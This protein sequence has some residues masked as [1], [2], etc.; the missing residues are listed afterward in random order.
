MKKNI[1]APVIAA[2]TFFLIYSSCT[3]I[4]TT[5]L[6]NDLISAVDNV[7]TFQTLLDIETDNLL[8]SSDTTEIPYNLDHA[9]GIIEND[10]DFGKTE[11]ALYFDVSPS[12]FR[13]Y[14]FVKK[15]SIVAIDSIVLS[16]AYKS[17][18]G[19]SNSVQRIEVFEVDPNADFKYSNTSDYRLNHPD[20]AVLPVALGG[21]NVDFKTLNDSVF[22]INAKDTI[23]TANELRINVNT[24]FATRFVNADTTNAFSN[25]SIFKT[26]LKGLA[27]KASNGASPSKNALAYFDLT[28]AKTKIT[29]YCRIKENGN[30][31]P[32]APFFRYFNSNGTTT[33]SIGAQASLIKRTPGNGYLAN[34]NNG[35]PKDDKLY[36]QS[37]PGSYAI[38]KIPGIDTL[39][40]RVIHRAEIVVEKLPA[41]SEVF[42]IPEL[43]FIDLIKPAGDTAFTIPNDFV[44]TGNNTYD[45]NLLGGK[46]KDNKY[47]FNI[48][49]HVQNI[50][51]NKKPNYPLRIYAPFITQPYILEA[52][53]EKSP[54]PVTFLINP[55]VAQGRVLVAGGNHPTKKMQLRIIYSKI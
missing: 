42:G 26:Y 21:R 27:V 17:L 33:S 11:A 40:N 8:F 7:P 20:F 30:I 3:K 2:F 22:Y 37:T 5:D 34:L 25:D 48:S 13:S 47:V 28:D 19:D 12:A 50:V 16:L 54:F 31:T 6:G 10:P 44:R 14:P 18:Y 43:L 9:I 24:S 36:L 4:D 45:A 41:V 53:G 49:R 32:I 52:S 51:T 46:I 55:K 1:L 39:T 15:D 38:L 23:R 35:N 29:F